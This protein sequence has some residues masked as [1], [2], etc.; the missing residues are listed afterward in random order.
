MS[1]K[2]RPL[3]NSNQEAPHHE[4]GNN[5]LSPPP[6]PPQFDDGVHP[7]PMQFMADTMTHLVDAVLRIPQ[8]DE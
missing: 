2:R 4:N 1:S 5:E 7:A 3:Y 8:P 6:S